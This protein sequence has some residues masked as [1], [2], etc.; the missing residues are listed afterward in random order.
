MGVVE[1]VEAHGNKAIKVNM[2]KLEFEAHGC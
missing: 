2:A 1:D